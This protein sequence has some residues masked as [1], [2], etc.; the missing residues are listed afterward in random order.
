[1][2]VSLN[3]TGITFPDAT[4]QTTAAGGAVNIQAQLF[5]SSSNWTAPT[6]VNR[7]IVWC[8][9]GG[10]AGARY[11]DSCYS[12]LNGGN[13]GFVQAFVTVSPGTNYVV[14]IGA[15]GN[16]SANAANGSAGGTSSFGNLLSATGGAGGVYPNNNNVYAVDG[17]GTTNGTL[18]RSNTGGYSGGF[19]GNGSQSSST[20]LIGA[21]SALGG[22][23]PQQTNNAAS[24]FST[25]GNYFA[26][27]AG[28]GPS[29]SSGGRGGVGGA[30]YIQWVA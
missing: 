15:G 5:T 6:G 29:G 18:I 26:G 24:A 23:G 3:S 9:G 8:V 1:M 10:G 12:G 7:A 14:T 30:V 27:A 21:N 22:G 19:I 13:G 4:T 17:S 28:D 20:R 2:A 16:G 11:N 25:T